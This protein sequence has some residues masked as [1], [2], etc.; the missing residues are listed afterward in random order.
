MEE[1]DLKNKIVIF[2]IGTVLMYIFIISP[3]E[4]IYHLRN[5]AKIYNEKIMII[6]E[7][8]RIVD[9]QIKE[10]TIEKK[11]FEK[12]SENKKR[13]K[14]DSL[15]EGNIYI[16]NLLKNFNLS[17]IQVN[18]V[19]KE[20]ENNY[21]VPYVIKG[22]EKNIID[23]IIKLEEEE[24]VWI[25]NKNLEIKKVE[26]NFELN[27]WFYFFIKNQKKVE[28]SGERK[29]LTNESVNIKTITFINK[30]SG[31]IEIDNKKIYIRSRKIIKINGKK[32][33]ILLENKKIFVRRIK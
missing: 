21:Y 28:N 10:K 15:G 32:Y 9:K 30:D 1:L 22:Q 25:L 31:I 17:I 6:E 8:I 27:V 26:K 23:F 29:T 2:L 18:R 3:V 14:F 12:S 11:Y 4:K 20:D 24:K 13:F 5:E 16:N 19:E 7:K 33:E